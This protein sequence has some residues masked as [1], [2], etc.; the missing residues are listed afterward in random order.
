MTADENSGWVPLEDG[1]ASAP[2]PSA[3]ALPSAP[4]SESA[5]TLF[6]RTQVDPRAYTAPQPNHYGTA[7]VGRAA[8]APAGAAPPAGYRAAPVNPN[9]PTPVVFASGS[10][11]VDYSSYGELAPL[12]RRAAAKLIDA[13]ILYLPSIGLFYLAHAI[14]PGFAGAS[15]DITVAGSIGFRI[16]AIAWP[17]LFTF[18]NDVVCTVKMEGSLGKRL[19][20]LKLVKLNRTP[21]DWVTGLKR[22]M[23]PL[24]PTVLGVICCIAPLLVGALLLVNILLVVTGPPRQSINDRVM[25]TLVVM[26]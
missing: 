17:L 15:N 9:A 24:V 1:G 21:L 3:R 8:Q 19:T 20:G 16:V 12:P 13:A 7:P 6:V 4:S 18:F 22:W 11:Q 5:P 25:G 10:T 2:D 14:T 26:R 23:V